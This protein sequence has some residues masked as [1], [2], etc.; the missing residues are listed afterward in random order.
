MFSQT[1]HMGTAQIKEDKE[2]EE[3]DKMRRVNMEIRTADPKK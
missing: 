2:I 1:L 3:V